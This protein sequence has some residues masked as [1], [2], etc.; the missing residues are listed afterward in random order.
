MHRSFINVG[1]WKDWE[2][3]YQE[4]GQNFRDDKPAMDFEAERRSRTIFEP[5]EWRVGEWRLPEE[6]TCK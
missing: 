1:I 2:S 5:K 4:V 3:F 6:S